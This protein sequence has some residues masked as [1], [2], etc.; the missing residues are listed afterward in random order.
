MRAVE[1]INPAANAVSHFACVACQLI[2]QPGHRRNRQLPVV[3]TCCTG[4]PERI[5]EKVRYGWSGHKRGMI[6][7]SAPP[8]KN[9]D[10][11]FPD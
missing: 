1:Q 2:V 9:N 6:I 3:L 8:V 11:K 10:A 4:E 7:F 5:I